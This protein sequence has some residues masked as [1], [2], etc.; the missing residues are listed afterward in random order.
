MCLCVSDEN[1]LGS[2]QAESAAL[3]QFNKSWAELTDWLSMLD[4]MVQNKKVVVADLDDINENIASLKVIT[5]CIC[6]HVSPNFYF[7]SYHSYI[8]S[9]CIVLVTFCISLVFF[10][11]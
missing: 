9:F 1:L 2:A 8:H 4:N 3:A 11:G 5:I 10:Y 6:E 7:G